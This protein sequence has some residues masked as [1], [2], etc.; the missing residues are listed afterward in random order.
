M[1]EIQESSNIGKSK[2]V[3]SFYTGKTHKD[4]SKFYDIAIFRNKKL[5]A[6]FIEALRRE[7]ANASI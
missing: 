4:G 2:Y 1:L 7:R 5:K 6:R 3:V